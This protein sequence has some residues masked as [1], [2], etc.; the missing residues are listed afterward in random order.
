MQLS[1]SDA[2][3]VS[4]TCGSK[5]APVAGC[6]ERDL[7]TRCLEGTFPVKCSMCKALPP[8]SPYVLGKTIKKGHHE[9][10]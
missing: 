4:L 10:D 7:V 3:S 2:G 1:N 9:V 5:E 8:M 6:Q